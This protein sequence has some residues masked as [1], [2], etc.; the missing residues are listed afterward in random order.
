MLLINIIASDCKNYKNYKKHINKLLA[1]N[2]KFLIVTAGG[3]YNY[4][5]ALYWLLLLCNFAFCQCE[6][7]AETV[8][9]YRPL[10]HYTRRGLTWSSYSTS[11]DRRTDRDHKLSVTCLSVCFCCCGCL[12]S[13]LFLDPP[14]SWIHH[15]TPHCLA[16][17]FA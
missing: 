6:T 9:A 13:C 15:T 7:M 8:V 2:A 3:T 12:Q 4:H 17:E 16:S 14:S 5:R 1:Q 10:Y 11:Q